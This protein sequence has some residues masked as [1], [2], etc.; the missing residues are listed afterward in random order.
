VL[1][2]LQEKLGEAHG[3]AI[4]AAVTVDKVEG[5]LADHELRRELD[6]MRL[7]ANETRARC[8]QAE[9]AFGEETAAEILAHANTVNEKAADLAAAWFKAG[10]GPL[11]AWS[12]LAMGEAAEVAVWTALAAL[13]AR[14]GGAAIGDL[15]SWALPVQE[16]HLRIALDGA[17]RLAQMMDPAAPRWG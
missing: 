2:V 3:L 17:A 10:T 1:T 9:R 15:A 4:A 8:L 7:E 13:A 12:F 5:R 11:A 14:D 6:E 16:R